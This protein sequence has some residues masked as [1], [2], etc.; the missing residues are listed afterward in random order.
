MAFSKEI[1]I[2]VGT[3]IGNLSFNVETAIRL[4]EKNSIIP[5]NISNHYLTKPWGG[6]EQPDFLNLVLQV[7]TNYSAISTMETLLAIEQEM[8]R[9]RTDKWGPRIIDLDLLVFKNQII[10]SDFFKN[11]SSILSSKRICPQTLG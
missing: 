3:N 1:F 9:I 7:N 6:V 11:S 5:L 4:L 10:D 8:G 2:G